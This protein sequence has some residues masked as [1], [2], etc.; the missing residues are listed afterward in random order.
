LFHV[1]RWALRKDDIQLLWTN[2]TGITGFI[3]LVSGVFIIL[4]MT[5]QYLRAS[6]PFEWRKGKFTILHWVGFC[7]GSFQWALPWQKIYRTQWAV[8]WQKI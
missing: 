3:C 4:P 1:L 5:S 7:F 2:R 6:M 8:P